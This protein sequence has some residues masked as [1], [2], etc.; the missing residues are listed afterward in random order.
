MNTGRRKKVIGG[1]VLVVFST[2]LLVQTGLAAT[3]EGTDLVIP[4][5]Y[6]QWS[7]AD[8]ISYLNKLN[9]DG[10]LST[11][12][13]QTLVGTTT[14]PSPTGP[15]QSISTQ[16][17]FRFVIIANQLLVASQTVLQTIK[18]FL[19]GDVTENTSVTNTQYDP[20]GR[21]IAQNGSSNSHT[22]SKNGESTS[23]TKLVFDFNTATGQFIVKEQVTDSSSTDYGT[24]IADV[25]DPVTGRVTRA[26]SDDTV[27]RQRT[28]ITRQYDDHGKL[29]NAQGVIENG[30]T[31]NGAETTR[32]SGT[33]TF[34]VCAGVNQECLTEQKTT[35]TTTNRLRNET[36]VTESVL[37]QENDVFART[38]GGIAKAHSVTNPT[39]LN[40]GEQVGD[41][42]ST[43]DST[44]Y[45]IAGDTNTLVAYRTLTESHSV[46]KT[47]GGRNEGEI[48]STQ[49]V[50][51]QNQ[52]VTISETTDPQ[53]HRIVTASRSG[54]ITGR[55]MS[56]TGT[57]DEQRK[58]IIVNSD[59]TITIPDSNSA[60][61]LVNTHGTLHF[62]VI[63][64]EIKNDATNIHTE[65]H[66]N[67]DHV[68]TTSD[69][70][71][72]QTYDTDRG[73]GLTGRIEVTSNSCTGE[74]LAGH[75]ETRVS[76][77]SSK[78]V[79]IT[80]FIG[81]EFRV[82]DGASVSVTKS[83]GNPNDPTQITD[84]STNVTY[85]HN[86]WR[87]DG[88]L[89]APVFDDHHAGGDRD[90]AHTGT[91]IDLVETLSGS[92]VGLNDSD[93]AFALSLTPDSLM[94]YYFN[95]DSTLK[96]VDPTTGH[97]IGRT[98]LFQRF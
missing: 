88:T 34:A 6:N 53:G 37:S 49:E 77:S 35:S 40:T 2:F 60:D 10:N 9:R 62:S 96:N 65:A 63:N 92:L 16:I 15:I 21:A 87:A 12:S 84:V 51:I 86:E 68:T 48:N 39:R 93:K 4:E 55:V 80:K 98:D 83:Y 44:T 81:G 94:S 72:T 29:V 61:N 31:Q 3:F 71:I 13:L 11:E 28:T 59:G 76:E 82:V 45:F 7:K 17:K 22:Q 64:N 20:Q 5:S 97:P 91:R 8:K 47:K 66:N 95:A 54:E 27:T 30:Q 73:V 14:D 19:T 23:R 1:F 79:F 18:N 25:V 90:I 70:S 85:S 24:L 56:A 67:V 57:L 58:N 26:T 75:P 42:V 46:D 33:L 41:R 43:S 89:I 52:G 69:Q 38:T 36:T 32:F 78:N 74:C 50:L